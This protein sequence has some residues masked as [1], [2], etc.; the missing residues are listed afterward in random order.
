MA[1][2]KIK[3]AVAV[4]DLHFPKIHKPTVK[5]FFQ[6]CQENQPEVFLFG[7]DQ[8]HLD[9]ISPHTKKTPIF[10]RQRSYMNDMEGF[11]EEIL[12]PLEKILPKKCEKVWITGN[13]EDW[14]QD[15]INE[16]PELED[17]IG[18]VKLLRLEKRGWAVIPLGH[19][20]KVGKL[21]CIH[22][23]VLSGIG[24]QAGMYPSRKAVE[25]YGA[26]VLAGHTHA[27]QTFTKVSPVEHIQKLQGHISP[28]AGNVNPEYLRNRPTAWLNGFNIIDVLP[29]GNYNYYPVIV[30]GG[31]CSFG[32][33][34]YG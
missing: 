5:C 30:S 26:S 3:Q 17:A 20:Y 21:V 8:F 18:H 2:P 6:Y 14:E 32:R 22:G 1:K 10:R 25:L 27:P 24:N 15:L 13:H 19:C 16:K 33:K 29:N 34:V 23:E 12:T 4:Y 31:V 28:I 9:C 7:G 11:D